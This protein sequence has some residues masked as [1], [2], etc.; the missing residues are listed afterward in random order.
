[1]IKS[2]RPIII[3]YFSWIFI[4]LL[5]YLLSA[6]FPQQ[7]LLFKYALMSGFKLFGVIILLIITTYFLIYQEP[8][9]QRQSRIRIKL[10]TLF[11]GVELIFIFVVRFT[12]QLNLITAIIGSA[13]LIVFSLLIG[14]WLVYPLK[15]ISDLIPLCLVMSFADIYSV[16][17]GPSKSFS[18]NISEFYQGGMK[19][20]PPFSDF[21]LIKFPVVGSTLP[22]P[23]IGVVDWLIIAFLSAAVLKFKF[24]DNL[25]GKSIASICKTKRYSPYL[26]ISVVGLLFAILISNFTGIFVPVLPV[27][28]GFFVLYLVFFIPEARQLSRSDWMLILSFLLLFFVIGLLHKS[29]L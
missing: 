7:S 29:F 5:G 3:F 1:M 9:F 19:G 10:I 21:L 24:S 11:L 4:S 15:R 20:L 23:I 22:Y 26:P 6:Y 12:G 16:F 8:Y 13:N 25:V 27:I 18:Y 14:T 17:I 2:I 28:A